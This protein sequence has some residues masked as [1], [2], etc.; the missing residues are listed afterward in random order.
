MA[1]SSGFY[2]AITNNSILPLVESEGIE[3]APGVLTNIGIQRSFY[4]KLPSP[5][6]DCREDPEVASDSD[7]DLYTKTAKVT[8]YTRNLCY[9]ICFQYRYVIPSCNCSDPSINSNEDRVGV[10][11]QGANTVCLTDLEENFDS[12]ECDSDCPETCERVEY[13]YRLSHSTYPTE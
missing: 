7:S 8:R 5:Y 6:S 12:T 13:S 2:V 10:C 9:K 4:N 11:A 1:I 3:V